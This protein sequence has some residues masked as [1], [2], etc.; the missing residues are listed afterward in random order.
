MM[1]SDVLII[2]YICLIKIQ[3][4]KELQVPKLKGYQILSVALILSTLNIS[5]VFADDDKRNIIAAIVPAPVVSNGLVA[6]N[7]TE[8][9]IIL[10]PKKAKP[11]ME[12]D[13]DVNGYQI[14][15]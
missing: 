9:N 6:K 5:G 4:K 10:A 7:P 12:L 11:G 14:P 2:D 3:S 13:P 15:T 1:C 8:F